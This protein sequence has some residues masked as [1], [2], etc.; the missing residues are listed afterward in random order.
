METSSSSEHGVCHLCDIPV[1][2]AQY[3][4]KTGIF[5]DVVCKDCISA[6]SSRKMKN[7]IYITACDVC[8]SPIGD[9]YTR[10]EN[11]ICC[12]DCDGKPKKPIHLPLAAD[13]KAV[14]S[15]ANVL[16][17]ATDDV[18]IS[19]SSENVIVCENSKFHNSWGFNKDSGQYIRMIEGNR[20]TTRSFVHLLDSV[21][22]QLLNNRFARLPQNTIEHIKH[23]YSTKKIDKVTGFEHYCL[24]KQHYKLYFS[25]DLFPFYCIVQFDLEIFNILDRRSDH[26]LLP[27]HVLYYLQNKLNSDFLNKK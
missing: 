24:T 4:M 20:V 18:Y 14:Y 10:R 21:T 5:V 7:G 15:D 23:T 3:K 22:S 16:L 12:F 26:I 27:G 17:L 8:K 19:Y 2:D 6:R 13:D 25:N 9:K 11:N 1:V